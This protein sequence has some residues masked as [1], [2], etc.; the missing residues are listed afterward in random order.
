MIMNSLFL[1]FGAP[2][3]LELA[4]IAGIILL[5]LVMLVSATRVAIGLAFA[6]GAA[7]QQL[8][9]KLLEQA[10]NASQQLRE[11]QQIRADD[12]LPALLVHADDWAAFEES[13]GTME[14]LDEAGFLAHGKSSTHAGKFGEAVVENL[15]KLVQGRTK[16]ARSSKGDDQQDNGEANSEN[17]TGG[18]QGGDYQKKN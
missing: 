17:A 5:L 4:I 15:F 13:C 8:R 2:G 10:V 16:S 18:D 6:K 1:G 9:Y 3:P 12:N 11:T 14:H 7:K